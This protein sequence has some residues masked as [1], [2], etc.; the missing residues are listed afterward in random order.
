MPRSRRIALVFVDDPK[1]DFVDA[2]FVVSPGAHGED[3]NDYMP[4]NPHRRVAVMPDDQF[5]SDVAEVT[6]YFLR[7]VM[8]M[9]P[10]VQR[11]RALAGLD[12]GSEP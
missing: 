11:L 8:P 4:E 6:D 3:G 2:T 9:P 12:E 5:A 1:V 7:R 10:A